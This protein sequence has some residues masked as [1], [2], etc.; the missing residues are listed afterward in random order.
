MTIQ[1]NVATSIT[2]GLIDEET[3]YQIKKI[4]MFIV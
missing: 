1:E 4:V 3:G 2:Y